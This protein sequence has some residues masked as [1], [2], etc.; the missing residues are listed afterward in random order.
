[1]ACGPASNRVGLP[2]DPVGNGRDEQR[3][4]VDRVRGEE[5]A[6]DLPAALEEEP[7]DA[8]ALP[9]LPEDGRKVDAI[10]TAKRV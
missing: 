3:E 7:T 6:V 1:V 4:L 9:E 2:H 5:G 8:E 10:P